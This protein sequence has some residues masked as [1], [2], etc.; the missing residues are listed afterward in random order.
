MTAGTDN[1]GRTAAARA[2]YHAA[3][4][5]A[6][7]AGVFCLIVVAVLTGTH[8][9]RQTLNLA[10]S[11]E[12]N[13]LRAALLKAPDT[14]AR[15]RIQ[16][17]VRQRDLALRQ[18]HT[19]HQGFVRAGGF[20]I[21]GSLA[22][23]VFAASRAAAYR[24][25]LPM[26]RPETQRHRAA[27][28]LARA[29]WAVGGLAVALVGISA[30][31]LALVGGPFSEGP[32]A[33]D[34]AQIVPTVVDF[35]TAQEITK[36]W[37]RFRGPGGLG[38]SAYTNV[39]TTWNGKTGENILWKTRVPL[40]GE[41][42]PVVWG[43]RVFLSGATAEKREVYCFDAD[44]GQLL[45][46]KPVDTPVGLASDPPQIAQDTGFACPTT[47][48]DGRRVVAMFANADIA[49]FDYL[50]KRMWAR[51]LGPI[52]NAYGCASSLNLYRGTVLALLDQGTLARPHGSLLALDLAT[53][54]TVWETKRP[55]PNSWATPA[56]INTGKRDEIITC[57]KPWLIAYDPATGTELWRAK[58]LGGDVAPSPVGAGGMVFT[59]NTEAQLAAV[60][61]GGSGDVTATH[62]VWAAESGLPDIVSPLTDG[63]IVLLV[64][65]DGTLTC[66]AAADGKMLWEKDIDAIFKSSPTLVGDKIYLM[67]E[68]G[69]MFILAAGPQFKELGKAELGEPANSSP[70]YLNGRI[71]I[72]GQKNL[73]AIGKK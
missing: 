67:T 73:Y 34:G 22:I 52:D 66:Y 55:V 50:G 30:A 38:I 64:T 70:A 36:Q 3:L 54:K 24:K 25:R 44:T 68:K 47:A 49:C 32:G 59:A 15:E 27:R 53:G 69:V 13:Q 42:S 4:G 23:G 17:E 12:L 21:L 45:W 43:N 19:R 20:L 48:T 41:N 31:L 65:T 28:T 16:E 40:P 61:W 9:R 1:S 18:E 11:E 7:V 33:G 58:V 6:I 62:R 29:R 39:P 37:P 2:R 8:L 51:N 14:Q 26:P 10:K 35:P 63:K 71:Y 5:S 60:R 72:R 46:A 56:L 57:G